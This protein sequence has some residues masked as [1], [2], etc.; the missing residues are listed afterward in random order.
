MEDAFLLFSDCRNLNLYVLEK[1]GYVEPAVLG[2][3]LKGRDE[4]MQNVPLLETPVPLLK[5]EDAFAYIMGGHTTSDGKIHDF[6]HAA[7]YKN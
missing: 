1:S 2:K 4:T 6:C 5:H 3:D 7:K